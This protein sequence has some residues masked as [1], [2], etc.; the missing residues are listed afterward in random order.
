MQGSSIWHPPTGTL[1]RILQE[2]EARV[3]S[4]VGQTARIEQ[5]AAEA[6]GPP[7]SFSGSLRQASVAVIAE[8]K[9]RSPSKGWINEG[10]STVDQAAAYAAGG[11]AA[12]SVLTEPNHFD[13]SI[14]DLDAVVDAVSVP[15]LR[16]DFH[17]DPIQLA[18][19]RAHGA[20]AALLIV[21]ALGPDRLETMLAAAQRHGIEALVEVRDEVEL[22]RAI[23]A[24]ATII[25]INNRDLET[26]AI[27]P[28][29]SER[30]LPLIPPSI[31]AV[32]ESGISSQAD[33]AR[34]AALGADAVLVGSSLSRSKDPAAL[35]RE[36][37]AVRRIDRA[38]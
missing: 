35:V 29:T 12:I 18:E 38:S 6:A 27:D 32:A 13:G 21:R 26:L 8:V 5:A 36:L 2:T 1:G 28:G 25:G 30:L 20:T 19:A 15:V 3:A 34:V 31:I 4:L 33:V 37:G 9:R 17:I 10:L 23:D 24:G 14:D 22:R 11:A 16:K 7:L